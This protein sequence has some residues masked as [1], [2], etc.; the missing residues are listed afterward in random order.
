[1]T[2]VHTVPPGHIR[3]QLCGHRTIDPRTGGPPRQT[4]TRLPIFWLSELPLRWY[5]THR[6]V[7]A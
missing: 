5:A 6:Q 3:C 7:T 1:M 2:H 4:R